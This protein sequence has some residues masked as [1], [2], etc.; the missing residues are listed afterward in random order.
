MHNDSDFDLPIIESE[1]IQSVEISRGNAK[2]SQYVVSPVTMLFVTVIT[3]FAVVYNRRRAR[4]VR[5]IGK[6]PGPAAMPI[7]GNAIECN[8]DHD[9]RCG[10]I[11][12]CVFFFL[13]FIIVLFCKKKH[14]FI[15]YNYV[16][17]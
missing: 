10:H 16:E 3:C 15:V 12:I 2:A 9:G 13:I 11:W 7:V 6:V 8:V 17:D 14:N 4:M 1:I 5:L